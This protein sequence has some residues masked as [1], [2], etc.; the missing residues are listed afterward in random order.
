MSGVSESGQQVSIRN[1]DIE[2]RFQLRDDISE[3]L[4]KSIGE[5]GILVPPIVLKLTDELKRRFGTD[6]PYLCI[7]GHSRLSELPE[8]AIVE[9]SVLTWN[10]I[11]GDAEKILKRIG[12]DVYKFSEDEIV[13][14]YILRL[15]ACREPLPRKA[16][17]KV[18]EELRAK[19]LSLRQIAL[20]MGIAKST[21][22]DWLKKE[23]VEDEDLEAQRRARK[24]CGLCGDWIKKGAQL[25]WF[26]SECYDK[27]V[28]LIERFKAEENEGLS[29]SGQPLK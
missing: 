26:H 4:S 19:N 22:H 29:E 24:Q 17:I 10:R 23:P 16:Y 20:M 3:D 18:A 2:L 15:H 21:L 7:D 9:C 25:M 14:T 1:G 28:T 11:V 13:Q 6:K 8:D 27:V 12:V 5:H